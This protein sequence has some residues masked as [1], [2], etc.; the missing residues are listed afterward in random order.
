VTD[1]SDHLA[2]L[3]SAAHAAPDRS[4]RLAYAAE[5]RCVATREAE[6]LRQLVLLLEALEGQ[7]VKEAAT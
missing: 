5:A 7:L 2:E 4:M 1:A 6:R 3:L